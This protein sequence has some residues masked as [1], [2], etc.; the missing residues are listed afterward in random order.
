LDSNCLDILE[1]KTPF[2]HKKQFILLLLILV[3]LQSPVTLS[4]LNP[5]HLFVLFPLLQVVFA[6]AICDLLILFREKMIL[7]VLTVALFSLVLLCDLVLVTEYYYILKKNG[8]PERS[9]NAAYELRDW[10]LKENIYSV[11][12]LD[13]LVG[14]QLLFLS[15]GAIN[16]EGFDY[17]SNVTE[18]RKRTLRKELE[19]KL[20]E[21]AVPGYYVLYVPGQEDLAGLFASKKIAKL[22]EFSGEDGGVVY[23][24]YKE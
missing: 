7:R 17:F 24:V 15:K 1:K 22:R 19:S 13:F 6:L 10:L 3:F 5:S 12:A 2:S 4:T 18:D 9:S 20:N 16:Y 21:D 23:A 8:A 14:E 11:K